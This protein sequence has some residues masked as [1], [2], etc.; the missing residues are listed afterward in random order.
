MA[1]I[2]PTNILKTLNIA[3]DKLISGQFK[4][5]CHEVFETSAILNILNT[6]LSRIAIPADLL[7]TDKNIVIGVGAPSYTS[8]IQKWNGKTPNLNNKPIKINIIDIRI[9]IF[10]ISKEE[11]ETNKS[12]GN[13]T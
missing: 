12:D 1:K 8:G 13:I 7:A 9:I 2:F 3:I 4:T 6:I 5:A 11:T 10:E